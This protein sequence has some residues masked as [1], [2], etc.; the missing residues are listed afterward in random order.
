LSRDPEASPSTAPSHHEGS[1]AGTGGA[2]GAASSASKPTIQGAAKADTEDSNNS[3]AREVG[4]ALQKALKP[5]TAAAIGGVTQLLGASTK[6]VLQ[7][8]I[9]LIFAFMLIW[10]LPGIRRGIN[11]LGQSRLGGAYSEVAPS[12]GNFGMLLGKALQA[13]TIIALVNT[14]LTSIGMLILGIPAIGFL[15]LVVFLC[16]FIPVAGVFMSTVP[17]AI[18]ALTEGGLSL[19]AGSVVMVMIAHAVEAYVLNPQ[20]YSA[21]LKLHPLLV[22][23]VLVVAEHTVGMW[24]LIIAVPFTVYVYKHLI[25]DA[26]SAARRASTVDLV[27]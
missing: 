21:H 14:A 7:T 4:Q 9:S 27:A 23:A 13:Q 8:I 22:L 17:I 15:S 11:G 3:R 25:L 1:E 20:I 5:Y 10:D 16:S 19:V 6:A 18:V 12:V 24:G 26:E 2:G